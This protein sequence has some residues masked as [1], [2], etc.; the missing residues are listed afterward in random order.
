M[1]FRRVMQAKRAGAVDPWHAARYFKKDQAPPPDYKPLSDAS[2]EAARL[3]N[4][5]GRAQLDENRR[6][7]DANMAVAKPIIEQQAK[8]MELAYQQGR[9]NYET[10]KTEGRPLQQKMRDAALGI[11]S[12]EQRR[13][14]DEAAV[15][16]RADVKQNLDMQR[17][18][19]SREMERSG[20]NPGSARMMAMQGM[21]DLGAAKASAGATNAGR[22]AAGDKYYARLGDVYNTYAGL[23]SNAATFYG[24]GTQAGSAAAGIQG[25]M[26]AQYMAGIGAGNATIMGGR[27]MAMQG[28]GNILSAQTSAYANSG[29]GSNMAGIGSLLAGGAQAWQ[30]YSSDPRLKDKI[31]QVGSDPRGFGIYEFEYL[32]AP[33]RAWRGVMADEVQRVCP[34]AVV[35]I[36]GYLAVHYDRIGVPFEEI[37]R[38]REPEEVAP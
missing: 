18:Q 25:N 35:E 33:G 24:V 11:V 32:S 2:A 5:L 17:A 16:A 34:D 38:R 28:L 36:D 14:M 6:Q 27:Q 4:E 10:F 1:D 19:T 26:G 30:A 37:T 20:V 31:V 8:T 7:Y 21:M 29:G 13:Q 9:E 15:Q 3:G 22:N 23:G 12:P